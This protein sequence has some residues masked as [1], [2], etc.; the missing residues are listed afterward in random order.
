MHSNS[1]RSSAAPVRWVGVAAA[2]VVAMVVVVGLTVVS[3]GA[4]TSPAQADRVADPADGAAADDGAEPSWLF[5][6]TSDTGRLEMTDGEAT[7]LVMNDVDLHTIEFSDR[8]D[9]VAEIIDTAALTDA[10]EAT[11]GDDPPNAVLVEH[12]PD[13]ET[14]SLVLVLRRP[15]FDATA[16]TLTYEVEI[17]ADEEHP[18]SIEGLAGEVHQVPPT[19][20]EAVSLFIDSGHDII[21]PPPPLTPPPVPPAPPPPARHPHRARQR[22]RGPAGGTGPARRVASRQSF[23]AVSVFWRAAIHHRPSDFTMT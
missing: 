3:S 23:D 4:D 5:S 21:P 18:E 10:W 15:V 14:D 16:R 19:E 22:D 1:T 6:Q 9:R 13:G 20:F 17:L 8:P 11:F 2:L 7:R 12:R